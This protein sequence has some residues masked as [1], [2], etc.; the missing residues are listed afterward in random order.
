MYI[1]NNASKG[2]GR[3]RRSQPACKNSNANGVARNKLNV[4]TLVVQSSA[5]RANY[6]W[7]GS[8]RAWAPCNESLWVVLSTHG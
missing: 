5:Q 2:C 8:N 6:I 7:L 4:K 3:P 1:V